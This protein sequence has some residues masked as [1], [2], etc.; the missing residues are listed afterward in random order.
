[1][2]ALI[3]IE[4]FDGQEQVEVSPGD[5]TGATVTVK[6]K[7]VKHLRSNGRGDLIV[8]LQ[9]ITPSKLDSK[10]KELFRELQ[11]LRKNDEPKLQKRK[12]GSYKA[13]R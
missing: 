1:L 13:K 11:K 9:V 3:N 7:G 4:T 8:T 6:G 10:Q 12:Q 2:G 5:Q